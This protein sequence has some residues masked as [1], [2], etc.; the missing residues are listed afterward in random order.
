MADDIRA[1]GL[2][3]GFSCC[4]VVPVH[5]KV[6]PRKAVSS[7]PPKSTSWLQVVPVHTQVSSN[8]PLPES[9]P[10]RSSWLVAV[11][12]AIAAPERAAGL[13][14]GLSCVHVE[15]VQLHVSFCG[16]L[17]ARPPNTMVCPVFGS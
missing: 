7:R 17:P 5:A 10:N 4:H 12:Q 16:V 14:A 1:G 3:D 15:P 11:S 8:R 9:P 2:L 6:S 13:V